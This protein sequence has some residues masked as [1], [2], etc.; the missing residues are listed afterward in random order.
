[1]TRR[2]AL[3]GALAAALLRPAAAPAQNH[4]LLTG[5]VYRAGDGGTST[6]LIGALVYVHGGNLDDGAWTGPIVTDAFGRFAFEN[7]ARGGY[8]LRV[9]VGRKRVWEQ[10]VSA[11]GQ[12]SP[13]VIAGA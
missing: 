1:V 12:L 3:A 2:V 13:I 11:P 8:V 7:L 10:L 6:A 5:A 9:F 4:S